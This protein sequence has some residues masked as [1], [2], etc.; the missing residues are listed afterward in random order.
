MLI[1]FA[2]TN[3]DDINNVYGRGGSHSAQQPSNTSSGQFDT[4]FGG[5]CTLL[6]QLLV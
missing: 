3:D 2:A 6:V 5:D 4:G 1:L